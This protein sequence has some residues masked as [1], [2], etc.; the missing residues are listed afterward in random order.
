[1]PSRRAFITGIEAVTPA[2]TGWK[3]TWESLLS[4]RSG[5]RPISL[6]KADD[7]RTRI[8]GEVADLEVSSFISEKLRAATE[9]FTH[10]A[11]AATRLALDDSR[12]AIPAGSVEAGIVVGCGMGGLPYFEQQAELYARKGSRSIRPGSVPRIMP[13][14][15][16]AHMAAQWKIRGHNVTLSTAC[17]SGNHAVGTALDLIRTGRCR[18][19]LCGGTESLLSPMTFAAFDAL[20]VMS[21]NNSR[22]AQACRPFDKNR[23]GFV[24]GE[25]AV[26][27]VLEEAGHARERGA[28]VY[29]EVA[30]YG[31]SNGSHNILAAEPDGLEMS[32]SMEAALRD[33]GAAPASIRYVHAHG[34]G[35][36]NNDA[37]ETLGIQKAFGTHAGKL[38]VSSTKAV[39]GHMLGAAGALGILACAL[40]IKTGWVAPTLN[41][42]TPDPACALDYV[43]NK[44]R[45]SSVD[46]ALS[47]A[48]AFGGNNATI[49]IRREA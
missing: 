40:S 6:F 19:V 20:H 43:P 38:M 48:F 4:G 41:Y 2:G 25:G 33:A 34:T 44:P 1:M 47:N 22:P 29:A 11:L 42:E 30:G 36:L 49:V 12:I 23:D 15:A 31:S 17:S 3:K 28:D 14:A 16:A 27:F 26:I 10:F 39:T 46:A 5:I 37:A 9:R 45:E 35:T 7:Y 18:V 24:M 8:A 13:N 32:Q 21:D